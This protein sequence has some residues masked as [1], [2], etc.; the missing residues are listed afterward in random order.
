V[1]EVLLRYRQGHASMYANRR[2]CY[3]YDLWHF[4]KMRFDTPDEFRSELPDFWVF[5]PHRVVGILAANWLLA[6]LHR[7]Q[8]RRRMLDFWLW[9]RWGPH[10]WLRPRRRCAS[11]LR[12][13]RRLL[14]G[15]VVDAIASSSEE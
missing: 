3:R 4:L 6:L 10:P 5:V 9:L 11:L 2:A 8:P 12:W 7:I 15:G 14:H 13:A 1:H